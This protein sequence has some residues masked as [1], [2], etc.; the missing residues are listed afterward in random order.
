MQSQPTDRYADITRREPTITPQQQAW[1]NLCAFADKWFYAPDLEALR[2]ALAVG[3]TSLYQHQLPV[4]LFIVG[5]P[6]SSKTALHIEALTS[7]PNSECLDDLT[8][9]TFL[10][11]KLKSRSLLNRLGS[12]AMLLFSDFTT[13]LSKR[14][15]DRKA[16]AGQLRRIY[17]GRWNKETGESGSQ[18]WCGRLTIVAA[19]TPV[20]ERAWS[21][22]RDLGERFVNVR[23]IV[24]PMRPA[25][26]AMVKQSEHRQE[27][28]KGLRDL[29]QALVAGASATSAASMPEQY[30]ERLLAMAEVV[31]H[32][33]RHVVRPDADRRTIAEVS[34]PELP[35]RLVNAMHLVVTASADLAGRV[36]DDSDL[37]LAARMAR[38]SVPEVRWMII[39][40]LS[41]GAKC[42]LYE[43]TTYT[44]LIQQSVAWQVAE[45]RAIGILDNQVREDILQLSESFIKLYQ[46]AFGQAV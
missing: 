21:V 13:F 11:A 20:I 28:N 16:I 37:A 9:S 36:A 40:A 33:R 46:E 3:Q 26:R 19:C 22:N 35:T 43:I 15:D 10:S 7:F 6:G 42:S 24:P 8:P 17:D 1:N 4:W 2:I 39:E 41:A 44:G 23:L 12:N 32:A 27:I 18:S 5:P 25:G 45:L 31:A 29:S 30:Y 38:D 34:P 14:E